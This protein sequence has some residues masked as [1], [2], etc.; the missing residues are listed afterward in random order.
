MIAP[1]DVSVPAN[2]AA[3]VEVVIVNAVPPVPTAS[4]RFCPAVDVIELTEVIAAASDRIPADKEKLDCNPVVFTA[5]DAST[6]S[7]ALD[8]LLIV[9]S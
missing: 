1:E 2:V 8:K 3:S 6:R 4:T 5:P 7:M 9:S